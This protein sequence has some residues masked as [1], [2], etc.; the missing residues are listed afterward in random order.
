M[1]RVGL[2][3]K[4]S[5]QNRPGQS[6]KKINQEIWA[7]FP[8]ICTELVRTDKIT[9]ETIMPLRANSSW[10]FLAPASSPEANW[11][12]LLICETTGMELIFPILTLNFECSPKF[13][14]RQ[15]V[16]LKNQ[17]LFV[18][19]TKRKNRKWSICTVRWDFEPGNLAGTAFKFRVWQTW[20]GVWIEKA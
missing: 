14:T 5:R 10:V 16:K 13:D 4:Q 2:T 19:K 1:G 3:I 7:F 11:T 12:R 17:L 15:N 8:K 20:N 6:S 9:C 18:N